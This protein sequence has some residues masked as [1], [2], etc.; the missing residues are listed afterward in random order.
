M[1]EY[2]DL[3]EWLMMLNRNPRKQQL[4]E[5]IKPVVLAYGY[6]DDIVNIIDVSEQ[7]LKTER[8]EIENNLMEQIKNFEKNIS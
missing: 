3:I 4:E 6:I 7:K 8:L 2:D 5:N 1:N